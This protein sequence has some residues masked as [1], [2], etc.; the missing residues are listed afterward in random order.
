MMASLKL[1]WHKTRDIENE[2]KK[3]AWVGK[4]KRK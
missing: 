2:E 3:K 4:E 1:T